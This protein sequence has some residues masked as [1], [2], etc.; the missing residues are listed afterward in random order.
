MDPYIMKL[1]EDDEDETMHSGAA[2]AAFQAASNR[3]IEGDVPTVSQTNA[4]DTAFSGGNNGS[5]GLLLQASSQNKNTESHVQLDQNFRLKQEQHSS[6]MEPERCTSV[7][8]NQQQH[9]AAPLRASKNQP[10][11]DR[12]QVEAEQVFA[13]FSQTEELQVSEQ[14]PILM[15]NSN[16]MQYPDNES[17]YLKLQKMSNQDAMVSEQANNSLSR[18]KQVPFASLMPVLMPQLDKDRGMQL[19]SLF[20]KL[21]RNEMNKDDF[22]RCIRS[23]VGNQMLRLAVSQVQSQPPPSVR[24]PSP[25]MPSMG[26]GAPNFSDS[27][28]FARLHQKGMN[29][30]AVQSYI[31]SSASQ[32]QSSSWNPAIDKNIKSLREVEQRPDGVNQW[33]SSSSG[34]IQ[35]RKR[36]S[37]P[38]SGLEKQKLHLQQKS[39][40]MYGNSGNYHPYTGSSINASS[41][42]SKPQTHE[43]HVKQIPQQAPNLGRQ[44]TIN[45]SKRVQGGNVPHLPNNLT[46]QQNSVSWKSSISKEQNTGPLS[47]M[48]YIKQQSSGQVSEQNK[49]QLSNLQGLSSVSSMQAEHVKT[50]PGIGKD[51]LDKQTS[52]M[53]FPINNVMPLTSS[54]AANFISSDASSLHDSNAVLS[55]QVPSAATPG[56]QNR[57]PQIKAVVGQ[58]KPL[59]TLGSSPP[60]PSKKQKL[61][62]AFSDQSIEQLNDVTVVSGVNIE[63]EEQQLFS[64]AKENSRAF[65][66]SRKVVQ[67]EERLLFQ[68]G[69]LQKM[70][71]EIVAKCGLKGMNNEVERCLSLCVEERLRGIISNL[72]RLSKQR[73][74]AEKPRHRTLVTSDVRQQITLANQKA[75]EEWEKKRGEGEEL[76]R[77]NDPEDDQRVAG[78]KEKDEGRMKSVKANKEEDDKMRT[79]AANVAARAAFGG[80]D[81]LSKWQLMAEQARQKREG[82]MNSASGSQSGNDAV[83]KFS[84]AAGR[85]RKDNQE[86]TSRSFG[87]TQINETQTRVARSISVKDLIAVLQREPQMCRST[88][89]YR[90]YNRVRAEATDE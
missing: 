36:S 8:D 40:S 72:I 55:S 22:V 87:S 18:S 32:G 10:H 90:S 17:Q 41:L 4:S 46:A 69:P 74:D 30:P 26:P 82:R 35:E 48:S 70:L 73:V 14:V 25:R 1:L 51:A 60:L 23:V 53:G 56:M 38:V 68:K 34:T 80:D 89:M 28:P 59:E 67:E 62:G 15:N 29:S 37:V 9:N 54:S 45:D 61:S 27:R 57:A 11:A 13:H 66:A 2:V 12:E 49:P 85:R 33:T 24:Q 79:T 77:L 63:E 44:V 76:R 52:K 58:K 7:P 19:Q 88:T 81:M 83:R 50:T 42:S 43:G 84:S 64:S 5:S 65:E 3:E 20:N 75:R 16:R 39:F 78:D 71:V 6:L 31:P 86:G 21:K 47:S